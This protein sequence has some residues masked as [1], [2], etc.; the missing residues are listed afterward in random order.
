VSAEPGA[1]RAAITLGMLSD[2]AS[3]AIPPAA[4]TDAGLQRIG[5]SAVVALYDELAL[6]PK[7]GLVSFA[8]SGSHSDMDAQTFFRSLFAL[9]HFFARVAVLGA[10][11]AA[12][13]EL[14][15]AGIAAESRML[16]ATGGVNCHRGA[17]FSLGLLCAAAGFQVGRNKP[18]TATAIRQTLVEQW[19]AALV[20]RQLVTNSM[21]HGASAARRFG[22]RGAA[23][24]AALGFPVLFEHTLPALRAA[25]GAGLPPRLARIDALFHT[26]AVLADTNLAHRAALAGLRHAQQAAGDFLRAGGAAEHD[27]L[28]RA[29]AIHRD[30]VARRLSP[31]GSADLLAAACW[32]QR[33]GGE[34]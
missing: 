6:A 33:V 1:S 27:G 5:R 17:I 8:D 7:P 4:A 22:L 31:G 13:A 15:A 25:S 26:I 32:L 21:S 34:S 9:R 16:K 11:G 23:S 29:Q 30:F 10:G 24:E 12:F 14:E 18:L 20:A 2:A 19:G 3:S 28:A